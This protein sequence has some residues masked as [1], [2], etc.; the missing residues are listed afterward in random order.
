[1]DQLE[2]FTA[3]N[4]PKFYNL[5]VNRKTITLEKKVWNIPESLPFGNDQVVP[6]MAGEPL[7]WKLV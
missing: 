4:G 3:I 5:A 2:W 1:M 6:L 7:G